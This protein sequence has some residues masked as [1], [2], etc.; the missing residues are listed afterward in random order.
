MPSGFRNAVL[1]ADNVDFTGA[2]ITTPRVTAD[3][4][5]LIGSAVAPNIRVGN[6]TSSGGTVVITPG[7]GTINLESAAAIPTQFNT[8]AGAAIPAAGI[9]RVNGGTNISTSGALN[10]VTVRVSG[11]TDHTVQVGNGTGSLT[12]LAAGTTGQLLVGAT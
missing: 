9:L 6:L 3:G 5:I 4:E 7:P 12:S 1:S 2:A 10:V 8:D 11:T